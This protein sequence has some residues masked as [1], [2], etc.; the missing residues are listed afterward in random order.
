MFVRKNLHSDS[1][2]RRGSATLL[3]VMAAALLLFLCGAMLARSLQDRRKRDG[4]VEEH[5]ALLAADAG[6]GHALVNVTAAAATN[7]APAANLGDA[8]NP[9]PFG[10]GSYWAT[11]TDNPD[12][13]FTV[14]SSGNAGTED[15]AV[16]AVLGPV[17]GGVFDNAVFAGNSSGDPAYAL[18]FGG[19]ALQADYVQG[20]VY[21]G[22]D[23]DVTGNATI[24]GIV[25]ASG[26]V[27]GTS[28]EEG[29]TL[30]IPDLASMN[31]ASTADFK[32]A[33]LFAGASYKSNAAGG[34]AW[35]V[36]ESNPAHIF[37]RNPSD[38]TA[39]T[40]STT[41]NDYFIEDPY[42]TVTSGT[43]PSNAYKVTLSG[44]SGEPGVSSNQKVFY[45]DGNLWLNNKKT[46]SFVLDH[47]EP[48]GVQVTF[49]VSGN[50]YLSDNF[51]YENSETD[52]VAF[53][54]MKDSNVPDSGNIYF[55]DPIFGTL[56]A[57]NAFMYAENNFY[58][59]NLDETGSTVVALYGNMSAGNQVLIERDFGPIHTKLSVDF[60]ERLSAGIIEMPGIPAN[61]GVGPDSYDVVHWRRV[62][63]Q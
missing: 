2:S 34:F 25:R 37:R 5:R 59:N 22:N 62:A 24:D 51:Y 38:R 13:T 43:M 56:K 55:G 3:A 28:G 27:N 17:G 35:Q 20:D 41:K 8:A 52:G 48:S 46:Y 30:P 16:E 1:E 10:G 53:I 60:D 36:P 42:E 19:L 61:A 32:V 14:V 15:S 45:I 58:D 7:T 54:A 49:V 11:V 31:Y 12:G 26:N 6:V 63:Q 57:L 50:V 44:I 23:V 33:N 29:V 4:T 40:S 39:Q 47:S 18:E 21:S 9:L